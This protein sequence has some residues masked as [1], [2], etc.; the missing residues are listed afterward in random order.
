ML[1]ILKNMIL[2]LQKLSNRLLR[3]VFP[4]FLCFSLS[5]SFAVCN[6]ASVVYGAEAGLEAAAYDLVPFTWEMFAEILTAMGIGTASYW[7]TVPQSDR[8]T[9]MENMVKD[10]LPEVADFHQEIFDFATNDVPE[11]VDST[12]GYLKSVVADGKTWISENVL[13]KIFGFAKSNDWLGGVHVS[14][15]PSLAQNYSIGT[16]FSDFN[17]VSAEAFCNAISSSLASSGLKESLINFVNSLPDCKYFFI[18]AFDDNTVV[19]MGYTSINTSAIVSSIL[20]FYDSSYLYTFNQYVVSSSYV[21]S[22]N[23]NTGKPS[24]GVS[25][26]TNPNFINT[27]YAGLAW[28]S[29]TYNAA[30]YSLHLP[31]SNIDI[32]DITSGIPVGEN[33]QVNEN[34]GAIDYPWPVGYPVDVDGVASYPVTIPQELAP[35]V[36]VT[37]PDIDV[38]VPLP[39][40]SDVATDLPSDTTQD[41]AQDGTRDNTIDDSLPDSSPISAKPSAFMVPAWIRNRF[42]FCIPF[43]LASVAGKFRSSGTEA[44]VF[45]FNLKFAID[46]NKDHKIEVDMSRFDD[47]MKVFRLG[48]LIFFI[49]GLAILTRNIIRS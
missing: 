33:G 20:S 26:G 42:P 7:S 39:V 45:V 35:D 15:F 49:I 28:G 16:S 48:E 9:Y 3:R 27:G 34:D 44:P 1:M 14:A 30:I 10:L 4:C 46:G 37:S 19:I 8:K 38:D 24:I 40:V 23:I 31:A 25:L 22:C 12:F 11:Y 36:I 18:R 13:E 21:K 29:A 32:S 6:C 17:L 47:L 5:G 2:R 41:K 43:D